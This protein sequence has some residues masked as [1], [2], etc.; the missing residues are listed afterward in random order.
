MFALDCCFLTGLELPPIP[1]G[2]VWAGATSHATPLVDALA[3]AD[4]GLDIV[5]VGLDIVGVRLVVARVGL[6]IVGVRLVVAGLESVTIHSVKDGERGTE[7]L[8]ST[9]PLL[10][11]P[12]T[13]GSRQKRSKW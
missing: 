2:D 6:D 13:Y 9:H 5:E 1:L 10:G 11:P 12:T 4:V 3:F 7:G 8:F